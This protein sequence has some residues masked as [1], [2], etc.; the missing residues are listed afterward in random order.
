[1]PSPDPLS[2]RAAAVGFSFPCH[3]TT[4]AGI[5][6]LRPHKGTQGLFPGSCPQGQPSRNICLRVFHRGNGFS[7]L[8]ILLKINSGRVR[9]AGIEEQCS[10]E[11]LG[12]LF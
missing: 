3:H 1:M 12:L 4:G 9:A 10:G 7:D 11:E 2:Q 6:F 5:C 8:V